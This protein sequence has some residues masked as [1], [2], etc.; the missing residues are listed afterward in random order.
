MRFCCDIVLP[1]VDQARVLGVSVE[2]TGPLPNTDLCQCGRC[3]RH[4]R[5][6]H[7]R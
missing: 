5:R 6:R 2:T 7:H 1:I 4:R 3:R